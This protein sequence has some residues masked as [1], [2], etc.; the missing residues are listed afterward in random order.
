MAPF[1]SPEVCQF[2]HS[3]P[4]LLTSRSRGVTDN[5]DVVR[6]Q[7]LDV[8]VRAQLRRRG[9]QIRFLQDVLHL[10]NEILVSRL[11]ARHKEAWAGVLE[12]K[13]L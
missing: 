9:A 12:G 6:L 1:G 11:V 3:S 7:I 8:Q 4:S 10:S 13:V 5:A 2:R